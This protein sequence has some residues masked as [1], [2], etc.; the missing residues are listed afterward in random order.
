MKRD[1]EHYVT[2]VCSCLRQRR[3]HVQPRAP[4][5]NIHSSAPFELVSIDFVHLEKS[6]GG[7]EYILVIVDHFT[8]FAQAYATKNKSA[9][10]AAK[11]LMMTLFCVLGFLPESY[12]TKGVSS[13]TSCFT[14]L[15]NAVAWCGLEQHPT[16]HKE[17]G[18]QND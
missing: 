2:R 11:K 14:S 13:R 3:P 4:M 6:S 16:I 18:K 1:I 17:M 8:R 10:T 9:R 7:Y 15:R 5:E 12:T